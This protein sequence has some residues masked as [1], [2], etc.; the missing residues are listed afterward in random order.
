MDFTPTPRIPLAPAITQANQ[1]PTQLRGWA[2]R[3]KVG[4]K[5]PPTR[6]LRPI[7][8][9]NARILRLTEA[10]GTELADAYSRGTVII[11]P[12]K[13]SLQPEGLLPPRGVTTS[14]LRP[15]CTIPNC[16]HP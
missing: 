8:P 9:D 4:L 13:R 11:I 5:R 12:R 3:F 7:I 2:A 15:L 14:G 6:S 1:Y 10:S 16:C